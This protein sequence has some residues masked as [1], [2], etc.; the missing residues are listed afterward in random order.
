LIGIGLLPAMALAAGLNVSNTPTDSFN[1][2]IAVAP[3]GTVHL[4]W[5]ESD[6]FVYYRKFS[7][8]AWSTIQTLNQGDSPALAVDG[9]GTLHLVWV[10][11]DFSGN[12]EIFYMKKVAGGTWSPPINVSLTTGISSG[13]DIAVTPGGAVHIVWVDSTP[14]TPTIY[15]SDLSSGG[16]IP[17]ATGSAPRVAVDA[18]GNPHLVWQ[19]TGTPSSILYSS[20]STSGWSIPEDLSGDNTNDAIAPQIVAAGNTLHVVWAEGGVIRATQGSSQNWTTPKTISGSDITAQVA[21]LAIDGNGHL[22]AVWADGTTRLRYARQPAGGAWELP[23]TLLNSPNSLGF[24][25]AAGDAG[26][27]AHITWDGASSTWDIFY[28]TRNVVTLLGDLNTDC[29]INV[30]DLMLEA[31]QW[32]SPVG[33]PAYNLDGDGTVGADDLSQVAARWRL[34]CPTP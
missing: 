27:T 16:P 8:G 21:T 18:G 14:G 2:A 20:R 28:D 5:E 3:D 9:S 11:V 25:A 26:T 13:P 17:G 23:I 24:V 1:P 19:M 32:G 4:V 33:D 22:H 10:D 7:G 34:A 15:Y 12:F 31:S 29:H 30:V 6:G